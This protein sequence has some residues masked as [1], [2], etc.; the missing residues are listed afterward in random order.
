MKDNK[1]R[2]RAGYNRAGAQELFDSF[3]RVVT[4][5]ARKLEASLFPNLSRLARSTATSL[6]PFIR[7]A[8]SLLITYFA[9]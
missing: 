7:A 6:L 4:H 1:I 8:S 5:L 3:R 9:Q 2:K